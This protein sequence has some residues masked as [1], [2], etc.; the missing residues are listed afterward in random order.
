MLA[1]ERARGR[2]AASLLQVWF[3]AHAIVHRPPPLSVASRF[4][5]FLKSST[6]LPHCA[7]LST[8]Q[9]STSP[10]S[11]RGYSFAPGNHTVSVADFRPAPDPTRR[12]WRM[13]P[14]AVLS[15]VSARVST[16]ERIA[17]ARTG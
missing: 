15:M 2:G 5:G 7:S 3:V 13:G 17:L 8:S 4:L 16:E 11:E 1:G 9:S 10:T 12:K 6:C 14:K